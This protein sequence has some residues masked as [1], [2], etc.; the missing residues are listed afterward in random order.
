MLYTVHVLTF[1]WAEMSVMYTIVHK[2]EDYIK[3]YKYVF[4][5][6]FAYRRS[7]QCLDL[8]ASV[9]SSTSKKGLDIVNQMRQ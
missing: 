1:E 3:D 9:S 2:E 5:A 7:Q 6:F 8:K 4:G